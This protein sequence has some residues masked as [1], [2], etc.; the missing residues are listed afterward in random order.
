MWSFSP[1]FVQLFVFREKSSLNAQPPP[2]QYIP[3]LPTSRRMDGFTFSSDWASLRG[4]HNQAPSLCPIYPTTAPI[5]RAPGNNVYD[6]LWSVTL[7]LETLLCWA[8]A[9]P[10]K[11]NDMA[12]Y[13][14]RSGRLVQYAPGDDDGGVCVCSYFHP[15]QDQRVC[16]GKSFWCV[17]KP[18]VK[19]C[20]SRKE[21]KPKHWRLSSQKLGRIWFGR[22]RSTWVSLNHA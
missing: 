13:F 16:F 17:L 3:Q 20:A 2:S 14:S 4:R 5:E 15:D 10:W 9:S 8:Q 19:N 7:S 11:A 18:G 1:L 22:F 21:S 6:P 12:R